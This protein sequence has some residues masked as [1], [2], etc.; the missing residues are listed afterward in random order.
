MFS[1]KTLRTKEDIV[2]NYGW[3]RRN[4][5]ARAAISVSRKS[6]LI[7]DCPKEDEMYDIDAIVCGECGGEVEEFMFEAY[8]MS[9]AQE[10]ELDDYL[11]NSCFNNE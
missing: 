5:E 9:I 1:P 2:Y 3:D 10:N 11:C 4:Q 8:E 6:K 7:S